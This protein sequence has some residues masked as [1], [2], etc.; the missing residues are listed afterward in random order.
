MADD[1]PV[2]LG[3]AENEEVLKKAGIERAKTV[4]VC[5]DQGFC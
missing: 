4:L 5:T 2:I 1:L 3:D